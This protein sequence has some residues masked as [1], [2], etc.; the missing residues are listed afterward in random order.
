LDS[1]FLVWALVASRDYLRSLA[2]GAIH[3]T[4]YMP[5]VEAFQICMPRIENQRPIVAALSERR[6]KVSAS[7]RVAEAQLADLADLESSLLRAAF[8]GRL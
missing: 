8:S 2:S 7:R 5:T 3:K 4:I 6:R 1:W